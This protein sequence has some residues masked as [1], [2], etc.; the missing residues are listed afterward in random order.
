[1]IWARR[2]IDGVLTLSSKDKPF[3][4]VENIPAET[5]VFPLANS[6][7]FPHAGQAL[8]IFEPRYVT[9]VE[10]ALEGDCCITMALLK[11]GFEKDY[12]GSPEIYSTACLGRIID[13]RRLSDNRFQIALQGIVAVDLSNELTDQKDFRTFSVSARTFEGDLSSS[14]EVSFRNQ[15]YR[16][17]ESYFFLQSGLRTDSE[18]LCADM[19]FA[20]LL[21][22]LCFLIP[23]DSEKKMKLL[24]CSKSSERCFLFQNFLELEIEKM[25][26]LAR[27][28]SS[29]QGGGP[30]P[31]FPRGG[32]GGSPIVH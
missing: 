1:M 31:F 2:A 12:H 7:L 26:H 19:S 4:N 20:A 5:A 23:L 21:D 3:I 18:T 15:F 14:Q 29:S 17:L 32:S 8:H 25:Q 28:D 30:G 11:P 24:R 9:M 22:N 27:K 10:N 13:Q 6:L 16:L